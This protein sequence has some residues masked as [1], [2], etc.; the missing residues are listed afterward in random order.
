MKRAFTLV[1]LLVVIGIIAI[2]ISL[3]LPT[4]NRAREISRRT[5]CLSNLR[6]V[7]LQYQFYALD[8]KDQV[9]LGYRVAKQFNS[10]IYSA[11]SKQFVLFGWMYAHQQWKDPRIFYCPSEQSSR[12]QFNT[13][14]NPWPPGPELVSTANVFSGY[15]CRPEVKIEDDLGLLPPGT[16]FKLP[17]LTDFKNKAILADL[18]NSPARLD[19]RHKGGV[20]VLYGNGSSK[21]VDRDSF[22]TILLTLPDPAGNPAGFIAENPK[23]DAIWQI[24]DA[25]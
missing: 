18:M 13:T 3:L 12:M 15:G 9:P 10:M 23:V 14:D 7:H 6:Q 1:E 24:F 19:Q 20:N 8:F 2:L 16:L 25:Q 11:T 22:N 21:W 5:A 17:R 4:L